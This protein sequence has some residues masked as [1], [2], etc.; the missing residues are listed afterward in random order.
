ME[1]VIAV[2]TEQICKDPA[3]QVAMEEAAAEIAKSL[4]ADLVAAYKQCITRGYLNEMVSDVILESP[5][6]E[7]FLKQA[8]K[9]QFAK[10]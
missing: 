3:I 9:A 1:R 8:L 2:L 7:R 4:K 10:K 5:E 6:V